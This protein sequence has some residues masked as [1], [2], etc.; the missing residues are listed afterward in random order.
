MMTMTWPTGNNNFD[1]RKNTVKTVVAPISPALPKKSERGRDWFTT[2][3]WIDLF[4]YCTTVG[5]TVQYSSG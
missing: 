2:R 3:G 5:S 4:A 1:I